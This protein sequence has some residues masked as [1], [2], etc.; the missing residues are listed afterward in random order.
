MDKQAVMTVLAGAA[1]YVAT[2]Q[3]QLDKVASERVEFTKMA[4][5][6]AGVLV[7]RGIITADKA[8]SFVSKLAENPGTALTFIEKLAGLVGGESLG[9]A[10]Q[11]AKTANTNVDPFMREFFPELV[12]NQ[13]GTID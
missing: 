3:P 11:F 1:N 6:T 4:Q 10:S 2:V 8:D 7:N 12:R 13:S 5:R 9:R